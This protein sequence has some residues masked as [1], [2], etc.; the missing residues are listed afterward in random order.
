MSRLG[1]VVQKIFGDSAGFDQRAQIGSLAAAAPLFTTDP[2]VM[3]A[4]SNYVSGWFACVVGANSPAIEDMNSLF[5]LI[6]RQIAYLMQAGIAEWN[7]ATTYYIG[8]LAQDTFGN[9][10]ISVTDNNLNNAFGTTFWRQFGGSLTTN[11]EPGALTVATGQS[12]FQPQYNI[13]SGTTWTIQAGG[14][15]NSIGPALVGGTLLVAGTSK[16]L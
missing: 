15:L 9:V 11:L 10:Y 8:S 3:Q 4:L 6:T 1:R 16:T 14:Y 13:A 2:T 5:F 12:Y 7:A